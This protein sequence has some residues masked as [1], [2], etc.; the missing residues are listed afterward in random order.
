MKIKSL[1]S[2]ILLYLILFTTIPLVIGSSVI[3]YQMYKS[4]KESVFHKHYQI[5]KQVEQE[6]DHLVSH[7]ED[8]GLYVKDKYLIK[9]HALLSGLPRVQKNIS[10]ILIL[11]ND[12]ILIDFGSNIKTTIFKGFDYSNTEYFLAIKNGAKDYWSEVYLSQTSS[13]PT[14]SYT[15]RINQNYIAV[16]LITLDTLN[17]FAKKFKSEDNSSLVRI[18]DKNGLFLAHPDHPEYISQQKSILSSH[19]YKKFILNNK[20]YTQI[21]FNGRD[22]KNNIGVYGISK[23]LGWYIIVKESHNF[24]FETFNALMWFI[25]LFI[26]LLLIVSIYFSIRLSK[27]ILKPLDSV[28]SMM[29]KIAHGK[30]LQDIDKTNYIELNKLTSNFKL[31]QQ[32]IYNRE[33]MLQKFNEQLED[34]VYEKTIELK[35]INDSLEDKI[36]IEVRKNIQ[37]EK[38][39]FES[40]K[41]V[42]MGEMIGNIA[43]QWRQPLSVISTAASGIKVNYKFGLLK[44]KDIPEHMDAI[45]NSTQFLSETIDTFRNFIK[46]KKEIKEIELSKRIQ[47]VLNIINASLGN[48]NI[49]IQTNLQSI[50][51]IKLTMTVGEL[52]QVIINIINN[53]KD[54]LVERKIDDAWIKLK[55]IKSEKKV[56]ITIEDNGGGIDKNILPKI[57][58]PY[59][60]TK[61]KSQGTGL[62]LH[63]SYKIVTDSLNGKIYVEN[64]SFGA[65]FFIKLPL[66]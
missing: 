7:I 32:K 2:K 54:V 59:F 17:N 49:Q 57:F 10:T 51:L 58:D 25:V 20:K 19:L 65:K 53:S 38:Q 42:Q 45:V 23:R 56:I 62:G 4:K 60:T 36:K 63:M 6:S 40:S 48:N 33:N 28:G 55:V 11:N 64:T 29:D 44:D 46:E 35:Q 22:S 52:D 1:K 47:D 15:L 61:H 18:A 37:Q 43:H 16:L 8:M 21:I 66:R 34:T 41:M 27:S 9:R 31:M 12:G 14:I 26:V 30:Y 50:E 13:L 39:I 5:L 3:L 24:I